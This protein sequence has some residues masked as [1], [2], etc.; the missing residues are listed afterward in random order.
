MDPKHCFLEP[1]REGNFK[2][3]FFFNI[4]C[5]GF[6]GKK[7]LFTI[8]FQYFD[9]WDTKAKMLRNQRILST[10]LYKQINAGEKKNINLRK[11]NLFKFN[12]F[13]SKV[14]TKISSLSGSKRRRSRSRCRIRQILVRG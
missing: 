10:D 11:K 2:I 5:L 4:W 9:P 13:R 3:N 14:Q 7:Y 1:F 6:D 12:I 8:S